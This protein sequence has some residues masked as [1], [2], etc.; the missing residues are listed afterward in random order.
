VVNGEDFNR[1]SEHERKVAQ[2]ED[3][4]GRDDEQPGGS[5]NPVTG[6]AGASSYEQEVEAEKR[7]ETAEQLDDHGDDEDA[8][9]DSAYRPRTG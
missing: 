5:E 6:D 1:P 8:P 9:V 3:D 7:G 4:R 2:E